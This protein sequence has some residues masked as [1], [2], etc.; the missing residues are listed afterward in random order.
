MSE[1]ATQSNA[2]SLRLVGVEFAPTNRRQAHSQRDAQ[3]LQRAIESETV[4]PQALPQPRLPVVPVY[5]DAS[6][7]QFILE[8]TPTGPLALPYISGSPLDANLGDIKQGGFA[9]LTDL[10][11]MAPPRTQP[12]EEGFSEVNA[13]NAT[14]MRLAA[15]G[16]PNPSGSPSSTL[17]GL[18]QKLAKDLA[19]QLFTMGATTLAR[20]GNVHSMLNIVASKSAAELTA[21]AGIGAARQLAGLASQMLFSKA[22]SV[23]DESSTAEHVAHKYAQELV[24]Q[25]QGELIDQAAAALGLADTPVDI[26][27]RIN[28]FFGLGVPEFAAVRLTDT[29]IQ[30]NAVAEGSLNVVIEGL[31]AGR[32]GDEVLPSGVK[33]YR[34]AK[35][36]LVNS[37]PAARILESV[38]AKGPFENG[39]ARTFIG[40]P[41]IG[42]LPPSAAKQLPVK[43]I[44]VGIGGS[45]SREYREEEKPPG[46]EENPPEH[47]QNIVKDF[48]ALEDDKKYID[49]PPG[50]QLLTDIKET[51]FSD[52]CQR[53]EDEAAEFIY[54][55]LSENP[56][57]PIYLFGH[58]RGGYIVMNLARRLGNEGIDVRYLGAYD[59]VDMQIGYGRSDLIPPNVE[60]YTVTHVPEEPLFS[61]EE[62]SR[63]YFR[64]P[65]AL[66]EDPSRTSGRNVPL[67]GTHAAHGGSPGSGDHPR[68]YGY[69][70]DTAISVQA[71]QTIRDDATNAGASFRPKTPSEY[72]FPSDPSAPPALPSAVTKGSL[73]SSG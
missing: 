39:A 13:L 52:S 25:L 69:E 3:L 20:G 48:D 15:N 58:S 43:P 12:A 1:T 37:L 72:K 4:N 60:Y 47:V 33:I 27:S 24:S 46:E 19:Q 17:D 51:L 10:Q 55:R 23:D 73:T 6:G 30:K 61:S 34:G 35:T 49:G 63:S 7:Q 56:D 40:G 70:N 22:W 18:P 53:I 54:Q 11:R 14:A 9:P 28:K 38:S 29:D 32:L 64:R 31:A 21:Q 71:D 8:Q 50:G 16:G 66:P 41:S 26:V 59:P 42:A 57:A 62:Q 45:G 5:E 36:V 2:S 67:R 44:V 68:G 65:E